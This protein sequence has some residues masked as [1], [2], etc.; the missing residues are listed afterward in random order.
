M[1]GG[2]VADLYVARERGTP[3]SL[4]VSRCR[5]TVPSPLL[6]PGMRAVGAERLRESVKGAKQCPVL[7]RVY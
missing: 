2:T 3:M 5:L 7:L 4:Y 6:T 1:T